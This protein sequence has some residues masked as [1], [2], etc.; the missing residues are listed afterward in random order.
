MSET[1]AHDVLPVAM[2]QPGKCEDFFIFKITS[3][4]ASTEIG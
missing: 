1:I 4:Q 2:F 3:K